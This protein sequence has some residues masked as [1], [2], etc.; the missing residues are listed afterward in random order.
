ML[1]T[2]IVRNLCVASL[3]AG[4]CASAI[5]QEDSS[6]AGDVVNAYLEKA[7]PGE[8]HARLKMLVGKWKVETTTYGEEGKSPMKSEA[9]AVVRPIFG[10]Q[11]FRE[12]YTGDFFGTKFTGMGIYGFDKGTKKF[13][14]SWID[15]MSTGIARSVG[16]AMANGD[17]AFLGE[18]YDPVE[19]RMVKTKFVLTLNSRKTHSGVYYS[20][21]ADG[22]EKKMMEFVYTRAKGGKKER[23]KN[24][25]KGEKKAKK[26]DRDKKGENKKKGEKKKK[27]DKDASI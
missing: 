25:E 22:S 2:R 16:T 6:S 12:D 11:Y 15:S 26:K 23:K 4:V 5:A 21:A 27:K 7:K 3:S 19:E 9:T 8:E 1:T 10:G 17:I 20:I 14:S 18:Y 13:V 24:A